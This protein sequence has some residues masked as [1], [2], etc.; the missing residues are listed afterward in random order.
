MYRF[1]LLI[2]AV[3]LLS[4]SIVQAASYE[5]T[6]G[7]TVD[8][9]LDNWD[10]T[11]SYSGNNLEPGV[12]LSYVDLDNA[13]LS[14]ANL[15]YAD[16][17]NTNLTNTILTGADLYRAILTN[18]NLTDANLSNAYMAGA[19][20]TNTNLTDANLSDADLYRATFS[21]GTILYD[22]QTVLQHGFDTASL[23]TYLEASPISARR[24]NNLYLVPE[25]ASV[26]LLL[27]GL[28]TL[29]RVRF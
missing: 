15:W 9:I 17:I 13:D 11:H 21:P 29:A 28:L 4:C 23:E 27:T 22:G 24:A 3:M 25:P 18:T 6:S 1:A 26:L 5:K 20:L 19:I 14:Y 10:D 2:V 8:P 7:T 16:L 12:M